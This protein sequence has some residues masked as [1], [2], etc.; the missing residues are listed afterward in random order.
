MHASV[1]VNLHVRIRKKGLRKK[2]KGTRQSMWEERETDRGR[3]QS[4]G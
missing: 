4:D 2:K 3:E 1:D